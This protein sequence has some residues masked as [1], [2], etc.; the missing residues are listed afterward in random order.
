LADEVGVLLQQLLVDSANARVSLLLMGA[1]V[2]AVH[3]A[4][5]ARYFVVDF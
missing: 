1:V 5:D 4:D 3:F 2:A